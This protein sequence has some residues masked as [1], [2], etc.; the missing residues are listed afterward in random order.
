LKINTQNNRKLFFLLLLILQLFTNQLLAQQVITC[1]GNSGKSTTNQISYTIGETIT[2]TFVGSET[3]LTQGF[4]QGVIHFTA[5]E[6]YEFP[7]IEVSVFPNPTTDIVQLKVLNKE[8]GNYSCSIFDL[9]GKSLVNKNF[10]NSETEISL[11]FLIPSTY[12]M[13]VYDEK[14]ELRTFKIVKTTN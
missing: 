12:L 3:I 5:I 2:N 7:A 10:T 1:T 4:H 8:P 13:K 11:G 14:R 9:S 6:L